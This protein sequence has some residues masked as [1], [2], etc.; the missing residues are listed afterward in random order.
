MLSFDDLPFALQQLIWKF[1]Y[2]GVIQRRPMLDV[3][4]CCET[5]RCIPPIFLKDRLPW[6]TMPTHS[7]YDISPLNPFKRG[8]PYVP[9]NNLNLLAPAF[10]N[11]FRYAMIHMLPQQ[12]CRSLGTYHGHLVT[13]VRRYCNRPIY[14]WN[15]L[16]LDLL[17]F[18]PGLEREDIYN[19]TTPWEKHI[20]HRF[21]SAIP[22]VRLV[23]PLHVLPLRL[24]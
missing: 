22:Q 15:Q 18:Y 24:V 11:V 20:I 7:W 4:V 9:T 14:G 13:K 12:G 16:A 6:H 5:R 17:G 1:A 23:S 3:L 19:P 21:T 10:S 2:F 8:N